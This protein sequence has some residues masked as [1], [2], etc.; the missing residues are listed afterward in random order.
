[1][2]REDDKQN[3]NGEDTMD[4][5]I[6]TTG[7]SAKKRA[8]SP[9]QPVGCWIRPAK[10]LAIY[11]RDS[12]RCVYCERDLRDADPRDIHL[13]HVIPKSDGGSN[14]E[15]NLVTACRA[16]NCSRQDKPI[17]RFASPE[18]RQ[19]IKR[20]TKRDLKPYVKMAKA[21]IDGRTG[22]ENS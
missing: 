8:A 13:D 9:H 21:I 14:L 2:W 18:A 15:T 20:L 19:D 6:A 12:F 3:E 10:R 17:N 11:L 22:T 5:Q 7:I 16:C 4:K 1:M